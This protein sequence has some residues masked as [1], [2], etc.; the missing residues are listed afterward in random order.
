MACEKCNYCIGEK[1]KTKKFG[2]KHC[3]QILIEL[4]IPEK[5]PGPTNFIKEL[6]ENK[7][8]SSIF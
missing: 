8:R 2:P 1:Y 5:I 3:T 6:S 7:I 4:F